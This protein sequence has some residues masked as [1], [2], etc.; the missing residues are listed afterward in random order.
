MARPHGSVR[1]GPISL[2]TLIIILCL[3]VLAVLSVT[4]ARAELSVTERQAATTTE[5]YQ[6][7]VRGQEFL[8]AV[9]G[10]L[11]TGDAATLEAVLADYGVETTA[12]APGADGAA[13]PDAAPAGETIEDETPSGTTA[14]AAGVTIVDGD[15]SAGS[16]TASG[17]FDGELISA[18]FAMDSGRTLALALRLNDD[19]AYRIEQWKMTTQ[20]IDDG[21]GETLWLG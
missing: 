15:G 4:T 17:T 1:I 7:E 14:P 11:A 20:W 5:T 8:A 3:A 13:A 6:L 21:T 10:S 19:G 9:D 16:I 12:A 18:T 2:F